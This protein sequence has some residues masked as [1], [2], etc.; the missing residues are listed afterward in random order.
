MAAQFLREKMGL[1]DVEE[2]WAVAL[3]PACGVIESR[4]LFRGTVDSCFIHPRDIF[5]FGLA[6]N[7]TSLLVGHNHPSGSS[8]PSQAD[9]DLTRRLKAAGELLQIPLVD[10]LIISKIDFYSFAE[11]VWGRSGE[12]K[13]V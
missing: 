5:R 8:Y 10:H 13:L 6:H 11:R 12:L 3:N 4:M 9:C 7:A 1:S 2:F